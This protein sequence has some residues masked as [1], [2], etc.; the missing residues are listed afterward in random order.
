MK[1][2][3][4]FGFLVFAFIIAEVCMLLVKPVGEIDAIFQAEYNALSMDQE[5]EETISGE[6]RR[7]AEEFKD[8]HFPNSKNGT[9]LPFLI[10]FRWTMIQNLLPLVLIAAGVGLSEGVL[11]RAQTKETI[12][13]FSPRRFHLAFWMLGLLLLIIPGYL[14]GPL[15]FPIALIGIVPTLFIVGCCYWIASNSPSTL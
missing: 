6:V 7:W 13:F 10:A 1:W 12:G 3:A 9:A 8:F 11:K 4:Y 2:G 14:V 15:V 5:F